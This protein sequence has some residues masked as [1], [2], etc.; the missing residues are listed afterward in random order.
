MGRRIEEAM[1]ALACEQAREARLT[2]ATATY[3]P[4]KKN[5][6]TLDILTKRPAVRDGDRFTASRRGAEALWPAVRRRRIG[7]ATRDVQVRGACGT[8]I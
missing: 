3:L 6:P 7:A 4:T 5:R 8:L 2:R 1:L